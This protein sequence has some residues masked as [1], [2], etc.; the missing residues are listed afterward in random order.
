MFHPPKQAYGQDLPGL[1]E[2][3]QS[4]APVAGV[5]MPVEGATRAVLF[6]HGNGEDLSRIH[7]RLAQFNRL[8]LSALAYD[9]P[10]YGRTPGKP[11]EQSV[12][13]AAET[14]FRH[15]VDECGFA[16]S[17]IVVSGY[18]IG[19]GPACLLAER[20]DVGGLLLFAPFKS[21]V[22]V[23]TQVRLMPF[24]PFPNLSRIG[25]T[26]CPVLILHGTDDKLIPLSHGRALAEA[27]G[28]RARFV[29]VDDADHDD[30][31]LALPFPAFRDAFEERFGSDRDGDGMLQV[32]ET[33]FRVGWEQ[34]GQCCSRFWESRSFGACGP[35]RLQNSKQRKQSPVFCGDGLR[36]Q[37]RLHRRKDIHV[38]RQCAIHASLDSHI[39]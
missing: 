16:P 25:R 34:D 3:G 32:A 22:R 26:R 19:S 33:A 13:A 31:C 18:S 30:I 28:D 39:L 11:T 37:W 23:V 21:A 9:Y 24:D 7:D 5:W 15:L 17:N 38:L 29:A 36:P 6:S 27:A 10:G 12:Y 2:M 14:A 35:P 4:N 1:I 20:H 8:G